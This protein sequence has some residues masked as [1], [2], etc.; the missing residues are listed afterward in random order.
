[1]TNRKGKAVLKLKIAKDMNE[2]DWPIGSGATLV[3]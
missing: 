2:K 1:M 3:G